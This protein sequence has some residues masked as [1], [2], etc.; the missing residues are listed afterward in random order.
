MEKVI[1]ILIAVHM[2]LC[3]PSSNSKNGVRT[4]DLTY[5]FDSRTIYWPTAKNFTHEK[6]FRGYTES[7]FYYEANNYGAA[8]HGGT[9]LD[10]PSH[11]CD[12]SGPGN[13]GLIKTQPY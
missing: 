6:D 5:A 7:G 11:F 1:L 3:Y 2:A 4:I 10:A 13:T 9:H 12:P 8:E